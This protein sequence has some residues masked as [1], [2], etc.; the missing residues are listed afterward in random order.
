ID[1]VRPT[2]TDISNF[3]TDINHCLPSACLKPSDVQFS[4]AGLY[5]LIASEIKPDTYQ[6]T[7]EYQVVDHGRYD[8]VDGIVTVLGAKY[9]TARRVALQAADLIEKKLNKT[10]SP[11]LTHRMALA[12]GDIPDWTG[13][14]QDTITLYRDRLPSDI[15]DNLIMQYG[16]EIQAVMTL[17]EQNPVLMQR[18]SS[19]RPTI[20]AEIVFAVQR[21]MAVRLTDVIFG[22]TGMG[23]IGQPGDLAIQR[24]AQIMSDLLGWTAKQKTDEIADVNRRYDVIQKISG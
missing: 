3:L 7:G 12:G 15:I 22:R 21:E 5:P 11:C 14:V 23:T 1:R 16:R 18:L 10:R 2:G 13:F 20:A 24:S 8:G 4:W 9:T 17:C 19:V 6:G